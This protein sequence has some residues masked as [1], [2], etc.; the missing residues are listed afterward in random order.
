MDHEN[1]FAAK[2][3]VNHPAIFIAAIPKMEI[4]NSKV[5]DLA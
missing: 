3:A 1:I 5:W 4:N 2:L